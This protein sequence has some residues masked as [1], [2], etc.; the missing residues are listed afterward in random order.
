MNVPARRTPPPA[1]PATAIARIDDMPD[2]LSGAVQKYAQNP[3]FDLLLPA[4]PVNS[5]PGWGYVPSVSVV[6]LKADPNE[7]DV[8]KVG[9]KNDQEVYA[10]SKQALE[11]LASAAGISLRMTRVD[12]RKDRNFCEVEAVGVMKNESGQEIVRTASKAFH[13]DDVEAAAMKEKQRWK[14]TM[15]DDEARALVANEMAMFRKHLLARTESGAA[16]R[17]IRA[18]LAIGS[19]MTAQQ[20]ARPKVLVRF[21]FRPDPGND[22]EM[23]RMMMDQGFGAQSRLFGPVRSERAAEPQ[24]RH[25]GTAEVIEDDEETARARALADSSPGGE[26]ECG[27][28][29]GGSDQ[30]SGSLVSETEARFYEAAQAVGL[31]AKETVELL[32]KH[33]QDFEAAYAALSRAANEGNP[34]STLF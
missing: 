9:K 1:A 26:G 11:K 23:K 27:A 17:V 24:T 3:A 10:Y 4:I 5:Q 20:I 2:W 15:T 13:M 33:G 6:Q 25:L 32:A 8:F 30:P 7:G 34:K 29:V 22:P 21:D 18:L 14:P 12:D 16:N 28:V 31:T 19:G